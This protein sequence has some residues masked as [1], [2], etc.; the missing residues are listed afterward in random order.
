MPSS[1]RANQAGRLRL[2]LSSAAPSSR[3]LLLDLRL[4]GGTARIRPLLLRSGGPGEVAV[5]VHMAAGVRMVRVL[6][7]EKLLVLVLEL[8]VLLLVVVMVRRRTR[9]TPGV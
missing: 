9:A 4:V 5:L 2:S 6:G 3:L 7:R 8:L 1:R